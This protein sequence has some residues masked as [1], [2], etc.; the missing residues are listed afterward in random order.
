MNKTQKTE[1]TE[2]E[3]RNEEIKVYINDCGT[4]RYNCLHDCIGGG[5][6]LSPEE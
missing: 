2:N 4:M 3:L 6:F 5:S 1:K